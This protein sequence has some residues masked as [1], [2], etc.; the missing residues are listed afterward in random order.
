MD[1][2]R[3][4]FLT[5]LFVGLLIG[6]SLLFVFNW[7][8]RKTTDR[9]RSKRILNKRFLHGVSPWKDSVNLLSMIEFVNPPFLDFN[10]I[11][12]SVIPI[13]VLSKAKN[14]DVRDAIRRTWAFDQ[15]FHNET[16]RFKVFF[17]VGTDDFVIER[18]RTEQLIF[19]DTIRISLPDGDS[20]IAYR[21]LAAMIWIR[22]YFRHTPF[23]I[24]TEDDVILNV[25]RLAEDVVPLIQRLSH[26]HLVFGWFGSEHV[27]ERGNYQKFVNELF[28]TSSFDFP[29]AMCLLYAI[30]STA[31]DRMLDAISHF[32]QIDQPGDRFLTGLLRDAADVEFTHLGNTTIEF[33]YQLANGLCKEAFEK[34]RRLLLCT[35]S[36]HTGKLRSIHEYF[37]VWNTL[38]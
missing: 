37:D 9:N 1:K 14:L 3:Q 15:T 20:F 28:P 36:L 12:S 23:Y 32:D 4:R 27:V 31:A 2:V 38:I 24:K 26:R 13:V 18:L 16:I 11:S 30:T 6:L 29:Y 33:R 17:L 25:K 19:D 7:K 5:I 22:T 10:S 21:E 35:S 8:S 34:N